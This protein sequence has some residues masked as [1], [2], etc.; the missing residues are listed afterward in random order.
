MMHFDQRFLDTLPLFKKGFGEGNELRLLVGGMD[1]DE[2]KDLNILDVGSADGDRLKRMSN[3]VQDSLERVSITALEP[4]SP[5]P[6]LS[7]VCGDHGIKW[8]ST[9]IEEAQSL[10]DELFD[11]ITSTHC[12]YYYYNQPLAHQ[13]LYRLLKPDGKLIVTLVSQFCVLNC[14]TEQL[15][16]PHLQFTFN[17]ESYMSMM[18]KLGLFSLERVVSFKRSFDAAYYRSSDEKLGALEYILARHRLRDDDIVQASDR[19]ATAVQK[20][21]SWSRVNLIM[22]FGKA[23]RQE[24][25][26]QS[27]ASWPEIDKEIGL[28]RSVS[29]ELAKRLPT[30]KQEVLAG[31]L[32]AFV[33]EALSSHP[34]DAYL[35]MV[36]QRI[37]QAAV[38]ARWD[39]NVLR[40]RIDAVVSK[41]RM[42]Q[43]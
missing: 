20:H 2:R 12:A 10:G 16:R 39:A 6:K 5:N 1:L 22:F 8:E 15:L 19:F 42:A 27:A 13:E 33:A 25:R 38:D 30:A 36:A 3:M 21:Q 29:T 41:V 31:D 34:R 23:G 43:S 32:D 7:R 37:V 24:V 28:L 4:I 35:T 40:Q 18:S 9:R 17:A 14:L 26:V 11:I